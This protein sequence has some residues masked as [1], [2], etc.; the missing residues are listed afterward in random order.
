MNKNK[1]KITVAPEKNKGAFIEG[2]YYILKEGYSKGTIVLC[3]DGQADTFDSIGRKGL[4]FRG[5]LILGKG[6]NET[7]WDYGVLDFAKSCF[8][9]FEGKI[10]IE[11]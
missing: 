6:S 2:N 4:T 11:C 1:P 7:N 8:E 3:T 9:P 10:I 5:V